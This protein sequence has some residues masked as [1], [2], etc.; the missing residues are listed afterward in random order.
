MYFCRDISMNKIVPDFRITS[1]RQMSGS[2]E[3]KKLTFLEVR[4][5]LCYLLVGMDYMKVWKSTVD[6][7]FGE[8]LSKEVINKVN[9]IAEAK[10]CKLHDVR[11]DVE[12]GQEKGNYCLKITRHRSEEEINQ[13]KKFSSKLKLNENKPSLKPKH[14]S[15][16]D[17]I[18]KSIKLDVS[19]KNFKPK[20]KYNDV[21]V[22]KESLDSKDSISKT[23]NIGPEIIF[24]LAYGLDEIA[25]SKGKTI[26]SKSDKIVMV[27][28][29]YKIASAMI[30][31][32]CK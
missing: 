29:L 6:E 27:K 25:S 11:F 32:K 23:S 24:L 20:S 19:P 10:N 30:D 31:E 8:P 16:E 5:L 22:I 21:E 17:L 3:E 15:V 13:D 12:V 7:G 18:P 1:P 26:E 2:E 9:E 14:P 4:R 28:S